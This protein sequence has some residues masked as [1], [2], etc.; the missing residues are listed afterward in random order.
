MIILIK[1]QKFMDGNILEQ[2]IKEILRNNEWE[3][4]SNIY[5]EDPSTLKPREKDI[6]AKKEILKYNVRLF[7]EC[8]YFPEETGLYLESLSSD[9]I[10]NSFLTYGI[11][12]KQIY[13]MEETKKLHFYK[14]TEFFGGKDKKDFLHKAINQSLQSFSAFRKSNS[15]KAGIYYLVI[16]YDGKLKCVDKEDNR[17]DCGNVLIKIETIGNVF[18]LPREKCFIELVRVDQFEN[19]LEEVKKDIGTISFSIQ[20]YNRMNKNRNKNKRFDSYR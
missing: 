10:K 19:F 3:T 2:K 7:I 5:Y 15:N 8:K 14:Y 18:N 20:F 17:K 16:A 13:E 6:I 4:L 11:S 12:F 1:D 9:E